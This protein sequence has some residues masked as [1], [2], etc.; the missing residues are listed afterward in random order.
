MYANFALEPEK[1]NMQTHEMN[2]DSLT[3]NVNIFCTNFSNWDDFLHT[4]IKTSLI[5]R[6][7]TKIDFYKYV[8]K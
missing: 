1:P 2:T 6:K 3:L 4:N 7:Y 5:F 8:Y